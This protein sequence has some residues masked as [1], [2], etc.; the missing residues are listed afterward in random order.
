MNLYYGKSINWLPLVAVIGLTFSNS[1]VFA[2]TNSYKID[3]NQSSLSVSADNTPLATILTE[4]MTRT[5]LEIR[6]L[7]SS[8][9]T[10]SLNFSNL[11]LR[12][13]LQQ[14][15]VGKNYFIIDKKSS[16][17]AVIPSTVLILNSQTVSLT[18]IAPEEPLRNPT[19]IFR[20]FRASFTARAIDRSKCTG[21]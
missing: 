10:V 7:P 5:G 17:G 3:W 21:S 2:E 19:V 8:Q 18:S 12:E 1:F 6:G 14:V 11:S 4:I 20:S 15:L 16:D 9:D 13:G